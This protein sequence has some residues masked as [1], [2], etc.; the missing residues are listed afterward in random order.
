MNPWRAGRAR[1]GLDRARFPVDPWRLVET[2][3]EDHGRGETLFALGNGHLGIR[4]TQDEATDAYCP[5]AFVN[6]L[7]ETF[8]IR[9]AEDAYGL[10]RVGQTIVAAPET[11][12]VRVEVDGEAL[13][14]RSSDIVDYRRTLDMAAGTLTRD[15]L[16]RTRAGKAVR[17]QTVRMVSFT[18]AHIALLSIEARCL[19]QPATLTI[20]TSTALAAAPAHK[21]EVDDPRR[22][23]KAADGALR[24]VADDSDD[25]RDALTFACRDSGMQV[26]VA[27]EHRAHASGSRVDERVLRGAGR[28]ERSFTATTE[29]GAGLRVTKTIAYRTAGAQTAAQ[30]AALARGDAGCAHDAGSSALLAEQRAWLDEHWSSA[31]VVVHGDDEAQQAVRWNLFQL[32]Q[33]TAR[34]AAGGVAAKGVSGSGYSGHYFWDTEVFVVPHLVHTAPHVARGLLCFR[35]DMLPA[36]RRRA[37]ELDL[38]GALFPWRTING[39][40]ASAYFPAG[41]AQFHI[42]AD[43]AHAVSR[44]WQLTEDWDFLAHQGVDLLVETA[45][46]WLGLGFWSASGAARTFH[47]HGVTGPDE[48]SALVDDNFFTNVSARA[49]LRAAADALAALAA[50]DPAVARSARARLAI[51]PGE[52]DAWQQAAD[53]MHVVPDPTLG[54][55]PQDARFLERER[56]DAAA[57][58]SHRRPLLLHFHP[59]VIY[60]RQV[61]K[62]ADV[63]MAHFMYGEQFTAQQK[64]AD[65]DYYDPLTTGDSTLS[66]TVQAIVAAEVG[67]AEL[68]MDYFSDALLVDLADLHGNTRDGVH[69]ASAAGVWNAL[70]YGFG[71]LRDHDGQIRLDPR[72]PGRWH[73]LD[74]TVGAGPSRV[75]VLVRPGHVT[76]RLAAGPATHVVVGG[77]PVLVEPGRAARVEHAVA[78]DPAHEPAPPRTGTAVGAH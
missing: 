56:W 36:A 78:T 13:D 55:H 14:L 4:G 74:F 66:A 45:R 35:H 73:G 71:G 24:L 23:E 10:A 49:N 33:A 18:R 25:H 64:R 11:T 75:R 19:G 2:E 42:D 72:L 30:L 7:H 28:A 22:A 67:H 53:A 57:T 76:L 58:P 63:V 59:L 32:A 5:G 54:V 65:F 69:V 48:Y 44:Y 31:D 41:T 77:V 6:G 21:P 37:R 26:A 15:V 50:H 60:R 17:V 9:H 38:P 20:T 1:P 12:R 39:Q 70:V 52:V 46:M 27:A 51:S 62:Q 43:I 61:V 29:P 47:L 16:W 68:A 3:P 8:P 40:E 34:V